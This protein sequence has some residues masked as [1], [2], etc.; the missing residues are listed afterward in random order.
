MIGY[1]PGESGDGGSDI[2]VGGFGDEYGDGEGS[3]VGAG[4]GSGD[5][6]AVVVDK[7]HHA[8]QKL[9]TLLL[10]VSGTETMMA[11]VLTTVLGR[12]ALQSPQNQALLH[13]LLYRSGVGSGNEYIDELPRQIPLLVLL[14]LLL[15]LCVSF[16]IV[17]SNLITD[18]IRPIL[19]HYRVKYRRKRLLLELRLKL[20][21]E[22]VTSSTRTVTPDQARALA[23]TPDVTR[24]SEE[25][26]TLTSD[27]STAYLGNNND[28]II[29]DFTIDDENNNAHPN[30]QQNNHHQINNNNQS[31][32]I[33]LSPPPTI[34]TSTPVASWN[35]LRFLSRK[36]QARCSSAIILDAILTYL[37]VAW[38]PSLALILSAGCFHALC[39]HH[40]LG[41]AINEALLALV[42]R[43][44]PICMFI[45]L[46]V[47]ACEFTTSNSFASKLVVKL[48]IIPIIITFFLFV[49][50]HSF[51]H[52]ISLFT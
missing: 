24:A 48:L 1:A 49:F 7:L 43:Y 14:M 35:N 34:S 18:C 19:R 44:V 46:G 23:V 42:L 32:T 40:V 36:L 10:S 3:T 11:S 25:T 39:V 29:S 51:I 47:C 20:A 33:T 52:S 37:T 5:A 26:V 45:G 2:G 15:S 30:Q 13:D 41:L 27:N 16:F 12:P 4:S 8:A 31:K 28:D 38:Q 21:Q 50:V 22:T 9:K 6:A 17:N